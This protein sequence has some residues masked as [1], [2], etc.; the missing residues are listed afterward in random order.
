MPPLLET[1]NEDKLTAYQEFTEE[2]N[3]HQIPCISSKVKID[4]KTME[5][6]RVLLAQGG[7]DDGMVKATLTVPSARCNAGLLSL[8]MGNEWLADVVGSNQVLPRGIV[9]T[10]NSLMFFD[11]GLTLFADIARFCRSC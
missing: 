1:E 7:L 5:E 6:N 4:V 10:E 8:A 11:I 2:Y 3:Q 9:D